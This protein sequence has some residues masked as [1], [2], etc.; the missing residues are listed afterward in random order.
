MGL[1]VKF[2]L[3][4]PSSLNQHDA[5]FT[6]RTV[7]HICI[8]C[9]NSR[10]Q[11]CYTCL[12]FILRPKY[13]FYKIGGFESGV[14]ENQVF[15]EATFCLLLR[16]SRRFENISFWILPSFGLLRGGSLRSSSISCLRNVGT[17]HITAQRHTPEDPNVYFHISVRLNTSFFPPSFSSISYW[18]SKYFL[19]NDGLINVSQTSNWLVVRAVCRLFLS[20]PGSHSEHIILFKRISL[21]TPAPRHN[22]TTYWRRTRGRPGLPFTMDWANY[23]FISLA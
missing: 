6:T 16:S 18:P 8:R 20:H 9:L 12:I 4:S 14:D 23:K 15:W 21:H 22:A 7:Q 17:I 10:T 1:F 5:L 13:L 3:L 19:S 2:W 11:V